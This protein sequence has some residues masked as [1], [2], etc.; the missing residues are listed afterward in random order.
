[1]TAVLA[2]DFGATSVRVCRVELGEG[3]P[4]LEVLHRAAHVPVADRTG[5]LR[6][7]WTRLVDAMH[8]GLRA[9]LAAGPV[10]S[11]GIDS[12]AVDYGLLDAHGALLSPPYSYR[13]DRTAGYRDI[14]DRLGAQWLYE[15]TGL[16]LQAFNTVFQVAAH[17][18]TEL[19]RARHL[20][21]LPE[22]LVHHLTGAIVAERTSAG[23]SG[24]A[25]IGGDR[26]AEDVCAAVDL[27][28]QL[29]AEIR[30]ATTAAGSWNGV[31]VHLVGGH[32][33]A[34]AVA[35]MGGPPGDG[36][37]FVASG[38]WLLVGREQPR[39]DTSERARLANFT[40]EAGV[41]GGIRHL[42]NVTGFWLVERCRP[43]WDDRSV[44]DLV[45]EAEGVEGDV[46]TFDARDERFLNPGDMVAE[47]R[48]ATGLPPRTPRQVIVR[49]ILESMV[50]TTAS[51]LDELGGVTDV[52]LF[53]GGAQVPL[54]A[55][56][57][58]EVSGVPVQ[59]GPVEA[60][61]LGNALVQGI[62][63][64]VYQDLAEARTALERVRT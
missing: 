37:A 11:I 10:A 5:H 46:P 9:G 18:R 53:G 51:V 55:R 20:L 1:V 25:E 57:L 45:A 31:P 54:L 23:A 49:S 41:L 32:D 16:Q 40:N 47:V 24:L 36:T 43:A 22:L 64:G 35:A 3:G 38:T 33:T 34:S 44:A 12:W 61:A 48:A 28:P 6:W 19:G 56:R 30:P 58:G 59:T 2:V 21:F 29:L 62:A 17:D 39:A 13:D 15:R 26:W 63:L 4:V 42:R 52:R 60:A 8:A 14:A 50:D 7:D 27:D